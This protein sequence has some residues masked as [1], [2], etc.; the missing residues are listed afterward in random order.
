MSLEARLLAVASMD[1][2]DRVELIAELVEDR[3]G[4][5]PPGEPPAIPGALP[6]ALRLFYTKVDG[7]LTRIC[8][9][10]TLLAP[11]AVYHSDELLVIATE[12]QGVYLWATRAL[13]DDPPVFGRF[14]PDEPWAREESCLSE[15]LLG[16]MSLELIL[17]APYGASVACLTAPQLISV[18]GQMAP[19]PLPAW[20]WPARPG[21]FFV[22]GAALG[23]CAP[24]SDDAFSLWV[25]GKEP[26][27]VAFL[28]PFVGSEWE[29]AAL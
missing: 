2:R 24:S 26:R 3:H 18:L 16:F 11:D 6:S 19:V 8:R 29:H 25:G 12:N 14:Q 23:F 17:A 10:N 21:R 20:R 1:S 13:G 28:R 22:R 15:F 7:F 4:P 9:Q 5:L 27:D